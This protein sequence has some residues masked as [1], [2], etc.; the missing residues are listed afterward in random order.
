LSHV[1][2]DNAAEVTKLATIHFD[3]GGRAPGL[4]A[5][6]IVKLSDGSVKKAVKRFATR[7]PTTPP[8][9]RR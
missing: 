9:G 2:G 8:S 4:T 5:A 1:L 6:C 7:G 3:G